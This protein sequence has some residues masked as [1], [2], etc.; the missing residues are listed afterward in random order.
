MSWTERTSFVFN[1]T[2]SSDFDDMTTE[3]L[4]QILEALIRFARTGEEQIDTSDRFIKSV[5]RSQVMAIKANWEKY[6][7]TVARNRAN[8][9]KGG[10]PRKSAPAESQTEPVEASGC[11]TEPVETEV[12]PEKPSGFY[13]KPKKPD[14]DMDKDM[15]K[16]E[17]KD[18]KS[19]SS[20]LF[21]FPCDV[22]GVNSLVEKMI[23]NYIQK[24]RYS[25]LTEEAVR[26]VYQNFANG[27]YRGKDAGL[28]KQQLDE[29]EQSCRQAGLEAMRAA[30]PD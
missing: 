30:Y 23:N 11:Q 5:F 18:K 17:E 28:W 4:G 22:D 1:L 29:L 7:E 2:N 12:N 10:R 25:Y 19:T 8:G 6:D 14:K 27:C 16:E 3:E 9:S 24:S 13:P 21:P 15:D 26:S 20:I